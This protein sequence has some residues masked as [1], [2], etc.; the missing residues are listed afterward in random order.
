LSR[1]HAIYDF[2]LFFIAK[3]LG[4][5]GPGVFVYH[6]KIVITLASSCETCIWGLTANMS[7]STTIATS[8]EPFKAFVM[9]VLS[10]LIGRTKRNGIMSLNT[11][12]ISV[13]WQPDTTAGALIES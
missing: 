5:L 1:F 11:G 13:V 4:F 12:P 2:N 3:A 8:I 10:F 9:P 6:L 7:Q